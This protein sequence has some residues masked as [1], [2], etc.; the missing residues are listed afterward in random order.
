MPSDEKF[1][2]S[3]TKDARPSDDSCDWTVVANGADFSW[4]GRYYSDSQTI[5]TD[6]KTDVR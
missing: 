3:Y 2:W 1:A 4:K 6:F 5:E